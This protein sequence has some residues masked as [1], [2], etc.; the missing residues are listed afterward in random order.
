MHPSA[1]LHTHQYLRPSSR[2]PLNNVYNIFSIGNSVKLDFPLNFVLVLAV[3]SNIILNFIFVRCLFYI[4]SRY[5]L[6][7]DHLKNVCDWIR[8]SFSVVDMSG[9][10]INYLPFLRH[11]C[12]GLTGYKDLFKI[13]RS[14]Y[15]FVKVS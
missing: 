13:Y 4:F 9:G 15:T 12:P 6:N 10:V 14:L 8:R 7:D 3:I 2:I 11:I 5:D 1:S